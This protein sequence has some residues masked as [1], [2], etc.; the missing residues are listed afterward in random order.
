[1]FNNMTGKQTVVEVEELVGLADLDP[2]H[3]HT[4]GIFVN[5]IVVGT[6]YQKQIKQTT[7]RERT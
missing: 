1:M 3:T 7:I 4:P 2:D 5:R 6:Q